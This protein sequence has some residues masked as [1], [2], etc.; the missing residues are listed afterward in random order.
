VPRVPSGA[1][2]VTYAIAHRPASRAAMI[3]RTR[4]TTRARASVN[5]ISPVR[6]S[7]GAVGVMSM[8][9]VS[10]EA[11]HR[12]SDTKMIGQRLTESFAA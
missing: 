5:E 1:R 11:E 12:T 2:I 7:W 8:F 9:L 3:A 4:A 6:A 10:G